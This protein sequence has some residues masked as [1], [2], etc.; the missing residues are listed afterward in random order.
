MSNPF[1]QLLF[2]VVFRAVF[3]L[4]ISVFWQG[5]AEPNRRQQNRAANSAC[6]FWATVSP[7][8]AR[9]LL[10]RRRHGFLWTFSLLQGAE[11]QA[12]AGSLPV[13]PAVL[14]PATAKKPIATAGLFPY[15]LDCRHSAG[16]TARSV[17]PA[18]T[19][20]PASG[21]HRG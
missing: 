4:R 19:S 16:P 21:S 2:L 3:G 10:D 1:C 5:K 8:N 11:A 12:T 14:C 13:I 17:G 7:S 15:P 18:Q 6:R 9:S 20:S